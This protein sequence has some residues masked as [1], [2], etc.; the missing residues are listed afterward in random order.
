[1]I[2]GNMIDIDMDDLE[3]VKCTPGH[4]YSDIEL[5]AM[6]LYG[7]RGTAMRVFEITEQI[8]EKLIIIE[9]MVNGKTKTEEELDYCAQ[10]G[11]QRLF[12]DRHCDNC[13]YDIG[14]TK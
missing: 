2:G 8:R 3:K 12:D 1:M 9:D 11:E 14:G 13:G 10:C 7:V 6:E 5:I 4:L